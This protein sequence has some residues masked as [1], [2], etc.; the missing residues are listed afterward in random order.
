M[1]RPPIW[2]ACLGHARLGSPGACPMVAPASPPKHGPPNV[3]IYDFSHLGNPTFEISDVEITECQF[4]VCWNCRFRIRSFIISICQNSN[5]RFWI[6][7]Y[8]TLF[9]MSNCEIIIFMCPKSLNRIFQMSK[10]RCS[11][12]PNSY[13]QSSE[14]RPWDCTVYRDTF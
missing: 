4:S 7:R 13:F 6:Q 10:F 5:V 9:R 2:F 12:L 3:R 1:T 14:F 8:K 11:D